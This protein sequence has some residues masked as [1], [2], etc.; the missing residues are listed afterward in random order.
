MT[1][2]SFST[3]SQRLRDC[4]DGICARVGVNTIATDDWSNTDCEAAFKTKYGSQV[5][6]RQLLKLRRS[7][8]LP[9]SLTKTSS[10]PPVVRVLI[11]HFIN[12]C[13]LYVKS[14]E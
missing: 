5:S 8:Q 14:H 6:V 12:D 1:T 7:L 4:P 9:S 11:T 13:Q 3:T 2:S 10:D